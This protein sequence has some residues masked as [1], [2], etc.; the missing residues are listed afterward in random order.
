MISNLDRSLMIVLLA[1][2]LCAAAQAQMPFLGKP[3]GVSVTT[4]IDYGDGTID[5]S[6]SPATADLF[7]DLYEPTG[8]GVPALKPAFVFAHGGAWTVG[9]KDS[10]TFESSP[11]SNDFNTPMHEYASEFAKRGYV[12]VSIDY[13][14]VLDDPDGTGLL[15]TGGADISGIVSNVQGLISGSVTVPDDQVRRAIEAGAADTKKAVDWIVANAGTYGIDP[16][17]IAVGGYSAGAFN[18]IWAAYAAD[19]PVAAVFSNSGGIGTSNAFFI[20][21][22]S[23]P[24]ILL[25]HGDAD[26][27]NSVSE[28]QTVHTQ[29]E[30][31]GVPHKYFEMTGENHYYL[32]SR[33]MGESSAK[34]SPGAALE[35]NLSI[36]MYNQLNLAPIAIASLPASTSTGRYLLLLVFMITGALFAAS[37]IFD[38][39]Q[40]TL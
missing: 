34:L 26:L 2:I 8:A 38:R 14:K 16:A 37:R 28:S 36:F 6:T 9:A 15:S 27:V 35:E 21:S 11:G 39:G 30:T 19:A 31:I 32:R 4:D 12:C 29:L 5:F 13:R 40:C 17:R 22:P 18:A 20:D 33:P 25:F 23:D 1:G 24:P 10:S 7:L 3:F